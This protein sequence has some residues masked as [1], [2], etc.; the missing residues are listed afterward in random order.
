MTTLIVLATTVLAVVALAAALR[1]SL[2]ALTDTGAA[3]GRR[4]AAGPTPSIR[5]PG[6]R[7]DSDRESRDEVASVR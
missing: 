2:S 6:T 3:T 5:R 1:A 4:P 7:R